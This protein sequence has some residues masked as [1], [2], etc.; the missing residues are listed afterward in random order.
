MINGIKLVYSPSNYMRR[1]GRVWVYVV[2][3]RYYESLREAE[4]ALFAGL[5]AGTIPVFCE[6]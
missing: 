5:R 1:N 4:I 3:G 6:K 2:A